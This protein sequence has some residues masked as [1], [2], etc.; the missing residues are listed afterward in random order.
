[1]SQAWGGAGGASGEV[2][3]AGGT[4]ELGRLG[5]NLPPTPEVNKPQFLHLQSGAIVST[6][7]GGHKD[8]MRCKETVHSQ[9]WGWGGGRPDPQNP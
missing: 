6:L 1:M 5:A 2:G 4:V 9:A 3:P 8:Q 7:W